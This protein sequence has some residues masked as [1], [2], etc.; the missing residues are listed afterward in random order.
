MTREEFKKVG[1]DVQMNSLETISPDVE[2]NNSGSVRLVSLKTLPPSFVFGNGENI[3]LD[4]LKTLPPGVVFKNRGYF[5]LGSIETIP[6]GMEFRND[7]YSNSLFGG[8]F[9]N[10]DENIKGIDSTRLLNKMIKDGLFD[11]R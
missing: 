11:R 6:P 8:W 1:G 10:W 9:K 3:Y 5:F 4:L 2:F 7:V